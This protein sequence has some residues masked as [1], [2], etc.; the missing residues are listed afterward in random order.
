M[1]MTAELPEVD[2]EVLQLLFGDNA[3]V[4]YTAAASN[5]KVRFEVN[6]LEDKI[7]PLKGDVIAT[8]EA[9]NAPDGERRTHYLVR[10]A[11]QLA[12]FRICT[13]AP[14]TGYA[15]FATG[16]LMDDTPENEAHVIRSIEALCDC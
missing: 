16:Q 13:A 6:N 7:E 10:I 8:G 12:S 5:N 14:E 11:G 9:R 15:A 1:T 3:E 4:G 2:V